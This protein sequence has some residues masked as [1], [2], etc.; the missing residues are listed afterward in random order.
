M[1][2]QYWFYRHWILYRTAT[3][4]QLC[5]TRLILKRATWQCL[6]CSASLLSLVGHKWV[7]SIHSGQEFFRSKNLIENT[8]NT[9]DTINRLGL[10]YA[11]LNMRKMWHLSVSSFNS[12]NIH[13]YVWK[14]VQ[15]SKNCCSAQWLNY[16]QIQ[17]QRK[18]KSNHYPH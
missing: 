15:K 13:S 18:R 17:N 8:Y 5:R 1:F 11:Q 14:H 10:L 6:T 2:N 7:P 9:P 3:S 12:E 4:N 16:S